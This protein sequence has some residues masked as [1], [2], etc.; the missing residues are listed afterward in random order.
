MKALI[1]WV[2]IIVA[3]IELGGMA[4][5]K[6]R[7]SVEADHTELQQNAEKLKEY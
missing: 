3:G 1:I 7:E 2:I 6:L 4:F 5:D